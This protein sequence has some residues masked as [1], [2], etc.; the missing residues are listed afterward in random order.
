M[1]TS[2][3]MVNAIVSSTGELFIDAFPLFY[4]ILGFWLF[5]LALGIVSKGMKYGF[6][7]LFK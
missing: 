4:W 7:K 1:T 5:I 6:K 2:T 3:E